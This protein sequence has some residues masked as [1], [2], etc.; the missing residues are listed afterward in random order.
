M[1]IPWPSAY[2]SF[3]EYFSSELDGEKDLLRALAEKEPT[4]AEVNDYLAKY[5]RYCLLPFLL[6]SCRKYT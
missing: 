3:R 6:S 5:V 2:F 4:F 1:K